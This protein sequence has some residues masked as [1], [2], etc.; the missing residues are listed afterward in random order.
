M[1]LLS[2]LSSLHRWL[3][4]R[5]AVRELSGL[6]DRQLSDIG[7]SRDDIVRVARQGR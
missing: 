6:T 1:F 7:L 5:D 2:I 4:H 3:R